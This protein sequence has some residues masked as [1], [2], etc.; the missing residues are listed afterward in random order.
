[1]IHGRVLSEPQLL[2]IIRQ[3]IS[4]Q[5]EMHIIGHTVLSCFLAQKASTMHGE[6]WEMV[7][8]SFMSL[9]ASIYK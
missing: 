5:A 3:Y 8:I 7:A 4:C 1:M 9:Q 2:Q 6:V